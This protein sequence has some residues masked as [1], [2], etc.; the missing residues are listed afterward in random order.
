MDKKIGFD[1]FAQL[2]V[3]KI[4]EFLPASF[5]HASIELNTVLKNN[6]L[7]LHGLTIR[8]ENNIAPNIYLENFYD[9]YMDGCDME[10]V[11][12]MIADTRIT[13]E[14]A[15]KFDTEQITN[16]EMVKDRI[17]P[18]LVNREW[19][20]ELLKNRVHTDIAGDLSVTYQ[21]MLKQDFSGNATVAITNQIMQMWSDVSMEDL[22]NLAIDNMKRLNQSTFEPMSMVL[23]SMMGDDNP[24]LLDL[25]ENEMMFVISN[26]SRINGASAILD[27]D[28]MASIVNDMD[29]VLVP[30]SVH[31]WLAVKTSEDMDISSIKKMIHEVNETQVAQDE[32]LSDHPYKYSIREGLL[33]I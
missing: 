13:H 23:A 9:K 28:L 20:K 15:E 8:S 7:T 33:P 2:V 31:E 3:D 11:L 6:D 4:R 14:V 18:K 17:V 12:E 1:E 26:Q 10:E 25:P 16:F 21:I 22:H 19:N 5:E 30:S 29:V 27:K 32:Q 24:E